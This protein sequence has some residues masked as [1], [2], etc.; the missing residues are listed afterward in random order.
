MCIRDRISVVM[1]MRLGQVQASFG[2]DDDTGD[3]PGASPGLGAG[4]GPNAGPGASSEG[5][6]FC[7]G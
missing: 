7:R 4:A 3:G 1:M 5:Y 2:D 6:S